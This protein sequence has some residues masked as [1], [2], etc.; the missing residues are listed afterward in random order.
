M[1]EKRDTIRSK[2]M[3]FMDC[4]LDNLE[5]AGRLDHFE[6]HI[7]NHNGTLQMD[8]QIKQREKAY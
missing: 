7:A 3:E 1:K 8:Q 5:K 4:T 2:I 6:I